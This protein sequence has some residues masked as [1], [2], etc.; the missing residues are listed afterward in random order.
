MAELRAKSHQNLIEAN[1]L[2]GFAENMTSKGEDKSM[3]V[4]LALAKARI[5]I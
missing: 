5:G 1:I 2:I 3:T 4:E